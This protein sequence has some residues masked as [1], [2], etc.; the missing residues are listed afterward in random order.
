MSFINI[1]VSVGF[2]MTD[3]IGKCHVH[4]F[5]EK[6]RIALPLYNSLLVFH[7]LL[8]IRFRM[9]ESTVSKR[10]EPYG[11]VICFLFP[12]S[13]AVYAMISGSTVKHVTSSRIG[14]ICW[15]SGNITLF[16]Y[17]TAM[18]PVIISFSIITTSMV[19][20]YI[21][22]Q[23]DSNRNEG[24]D[25]VVDETRHPS[26][27]QR[28]NA[29]QAALYYL[30]FIIAW[31]FVIVGYTETIFQHDCSFLF[32][33]LQVVLVPSQYLFIACIYTRPIIIQLRKY[34][35]HQSWAWAVGVVLLTPR[36]ILR[37]FTTPANTPQHDVISGI[38][39]ITHTNFGG[40]DPGNEWCCISLF[41]TK[42]LNSVI[43]THEDCAIEWH[44]QKINLTS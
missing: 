10:I 4:V 5:F 42:K 31:F 17:T 3:I 33:F 14:N 21:H 11:H 37:Y 44:H 18:I 38:S 26:A 30:A 41:I 23:H 1:I 9:S 8:S 20:I 12:L 28:E 24:N 27:E 32:R 36:H 40:V 15:H 43:N 7:Y 22:V 16:N 34:N 2:F 19:I 35:P 29:T 39:S 6:L 25:S 13:S